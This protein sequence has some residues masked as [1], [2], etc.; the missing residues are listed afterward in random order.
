MRWPEGKYGLPMVASSLCPSSTNFSWAT[1]SRYHD[2]VGTNKRSTN[3]HLATSVNKYSVEQRFCIK[4]VDTD[5]DSRPSWPEGR[6]CVYK[7]GNSCPYGLT[8]GWVFWDDKN[9]ANKNTKEGVLP[10]GTYNED[11][12]IFFCCQTVG[13]VFQTIY[14]PAD[15]PFYLI[16]FKSLFAPNPACQNMNGA[17]ATVEY[18]RFGVENNITLNMGGVFPY[19]VD[20]KPEPYIY[21]CYYSGKFT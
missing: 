12:K 7:K 6:Y 18:I 5:Y 21:Y 8:E 13:S 11:T 14:L 1:G 4:D 10:N 20:R 17:I 15:K 3:F 2:T 9:M 16:A 19:G